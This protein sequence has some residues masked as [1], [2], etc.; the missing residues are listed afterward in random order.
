MK[1]E[2]KVKQG[3]FL[4]PKFYAIIDENENIKMK[5]AGISS[6][7]LYPDFLDI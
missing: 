5:T 4:A 2:L 7:L 1:L 3:I 6:P